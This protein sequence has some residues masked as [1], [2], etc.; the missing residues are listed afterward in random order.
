LVRALVASNMTADICPPGRR[1]DGG[2]DRPERVRAIASID[3]ACSTLGFLTLR[4]VTMGFV[5]MGFVTMGFVTMG[6]SKQR[7]VTATLDERLF[8]VKGKPERMFAPNV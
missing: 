5:T 4:F 2:S 7:G 3:A 8:G 1:G 6:R